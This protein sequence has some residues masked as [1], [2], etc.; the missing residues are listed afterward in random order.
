[1]RR[2]RPARTIDK[3]PSVYDVVGV[4]FGPANLALAVAI[5]EHNAAAAP[6]DRVSALFAERQP[7]FGWHRGM[8]IEGA[9]MQVSFLKDLAT[10]RN[11]ASGFSFL[12][13][14]QD[15]GRLVDFINHKTFFP[16]RTEFHDYFSWAAGKVAHMASYGSEVASVAPLGD[17]CEEIGGFALELADGRTVSGRNLVVSGGL[18]PSMPAGVQQSERVWHNHGLLTNLAARTGPEPKRWTVVGAGQSAAEV[19]D[20]LHRAFPEAE[21]YSVFS[22]YGYSPADDSPFANR[23]FDPEA[24]D[25]FHGAPE[26]VKRQ[27]FDY[28]RGTNYSV[29]DT[30]LIEELYRR[31]YQEKVTGAR[32]LHMLNAC[33]VLDVREVPGGARTTYEFTPTGE[34]AVLDSDIVVCATGYRP[35]DALGLLGAAGGLCLRDEQGRPVVE[36][37]YRVATDPRLTAGIYLQGGTEHTHGITSSLLSNGAVRAGEILDSV[38]TAR[39]SRAGAVAA[40]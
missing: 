9:T 36:R 29:V 27:L 3:E 1:M 23:I 13:Y 8:L 6:G 40:R 35:F 21:V 28:H 37:D 16:T 11:P 32:R 14:L 18:Q 20:H 38:L 15:K 26:H 7:R 4:G 24:V 31:V 2:D 34:R 22:R 19:T 25:L 33:R 5:E 30:D 12:C 17:G 10:M 39:A